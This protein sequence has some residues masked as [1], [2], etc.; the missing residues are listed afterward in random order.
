MLNRTLEKRDTIDKGCDDR[1]AN[2]EKLNLESGR[3]N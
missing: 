1:K 2:K 3:T